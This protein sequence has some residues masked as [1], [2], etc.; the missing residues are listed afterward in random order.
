[1]DTDNS[2]VMARRKG[3]GGWVEVGKGGGATSVIVP[4][5]KIYREKPHS[6]FAT[7]TL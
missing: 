3:A 7:L 5:I 6:N 1:M 4:K 2:V